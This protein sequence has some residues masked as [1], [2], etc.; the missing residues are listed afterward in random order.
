LGSP[1]SRHE[2]AWNEE[3]WTDY[4]STIFAVSGRRLLL[5]SWFLF[6]QPFRPGIMIEGSFSYK[7]MITG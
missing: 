1:S 4:F 6:S 5:A 3:A 2:A 7:W